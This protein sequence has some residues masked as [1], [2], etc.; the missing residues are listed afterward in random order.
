LAYS[1]AQVHSGIL[2]NED[3][4]KDSEFPLFSVANEVLFARKTRGM[5]PQA[6]AAI[7]RLQPYNRPDPTKD[8]LWVLNRLSNIDKHRLLLTSALANMSGIPRGDGSFAV[9]SIELESHFLEGDAKIA[10][11]TV[12]PTGSSKKVNVQY[13]PIIEVVFKC[14][15]L[16]DSNSVEQVLIAIIRRISSVTAELDQFL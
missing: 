7:E 13:M 10:T 16:V 9:E 14:G 5:S 1:L 8:I 6:Q 12:R 4:A 3:I 2:L 15:C 11:L